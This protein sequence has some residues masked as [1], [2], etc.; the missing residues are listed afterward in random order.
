MP[1]RKKSWNWLLEWPRSSNQIIGLI[2]SG[3]SCFHMCVFVPGAYED[4]NIRDIY[5]KYLFTAKS[6]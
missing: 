6:H 2:V 1:E 5:G 4:D 3:V